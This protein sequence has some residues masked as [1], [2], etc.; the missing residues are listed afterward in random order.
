MA[1]GELWLREAVLVHHDLTLL[2]VGPGEDAPGLVG[3]RARAKEGEREA[4]AVPADGASSSSALSSRARRTRAPQGE[5]EPPLLIESENL[6]QGCADIVSALCQRFREHLLGRRVD[7]ADVAI[8]LEGRTDLQQAI[9]GALRRVGWGEV[10]TYGQLAALAGRPR[11]ARAA[12]SFC[13]ESTWSLV[14][15]CHRVVA[16]GGLG[17]YGVT[18]TA[19]K[20]RLLAIEGV[21]A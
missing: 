19:T 1:R 10:V 7:Y 17:G 12:G 5:R 18:G 16:A 4:R 8:D 9:A 20:R 6:S 21:D 2:G 13:A 14:V 3:A 15:P 11:A